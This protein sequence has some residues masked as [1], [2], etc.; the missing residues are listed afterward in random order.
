MPICRKIVHDS[1]FDTG[2]DWIF[3]WIFGRSIHTFHSTERQVRCEQDGTWG[4]PWRLDR[5]FDKRPGQSTVEN[6]NSF[7]WWYNV[8]S[9]GFF[10]AITAS[11]LCVC[12]ERI[13]AKL[14]LG[15]RSKCACGRQLRWGENTPILGWLRSR[16]VASCCGVRI[17]RRYLYSEIFLAG[18]WA[19]AGGFW[20]SSIVL[21]GS[22]GL[23]SA[24][25]VLAATWRRDA[26]QSAL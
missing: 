25:A 8:L 26:N 23:A 24:V 19:A 6:V 11:F 10:G 7:N 14:S 17:P 4:G 22:I 1:T 2:F 15:G 3:D 9:G 21:S 20:G 13:P 12:S 16:G 18:A 5:E